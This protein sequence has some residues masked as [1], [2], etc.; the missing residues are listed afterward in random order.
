VVA[1]IPFARRRAR[2]VRR[3]VPAMG[4]LAEL[5]V[6]HREPRYAQAALD[7]AAAALLRVE[8]LMSRFS[9]TSDV[10]RVN[11]LAAREGV[12][13]SRETA[14]V[15]EAGLDWAVRTD[16]AFDPCVGSVVELWDVTRR[17]EPP[18]PAAVARLAGRAFFR[19]VD[20]ASFRHGTAVRLSDPDARIDLG[21]IA[22]GYGVDRAVATL[23][24]WGIPRGLVNVG[25]D[26]YA[27][28]ASEDGDPWRIGIR[29]PD[30]PARLIREVALRDAAITTSGDYAQFFEHRGRRYHHLMDPTT[31]APT[32]P[33]FHS[34]TV[35]A[36]DCMTADAGATAA[37]VA[38][39]HRMEQVLRAHPGGA[40]LVSAV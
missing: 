13:V 31:A 29:A 5:A 9:P 4:T 15:L 25:G 19:Q 10:G 11:R 36:D 37:F 34:I 14:V 12:P 18:A 21:G 32:V 6:L 2:L 27:L 3:T 23:R 16:G 20:L 8:R 7:A 26:I 28:G 22:V 40:R 38:S 1:T 30:D 39:A 17:R 33:R 24:D 35:Q